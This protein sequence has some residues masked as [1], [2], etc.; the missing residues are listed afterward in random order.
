MADEP[1]D[2]T[3]SGDEYAVRVRAYAAAHFD[4]DEH[5][6]VRWPDATAFFVSEYTGGEDGRAYPVTI[7]GEI[8]GA[9]ESFAEAEQRLGASVR[10][11]FSILAVASNA[12]MRDPL[13]VASYGLDLS[14]PQPFTGY[15]TPRADEWFPPGARRFDVEATLALMTAVGH[16]PQTDLLHRAIESYRRAVG[17]WVPEEHLLAGEFLFIAAETLSRFLIESRAHAAGITPK[18][19]AR[20][21]GLDPERLRARYLLD[22]VFGRDQAALDA[23]RSASDGFEHGYM[24]VEDVRGL[25]E[26]A[27]EHSMSL[28]RRALIV[29]SGVDAEMSER[30]LASEYDDPRGLVPVVQ[31]MQGK[32]RASDPGDAPALEMAAVDLDWTGSRP[33]AST[34]DEGGVDVTFSTNVRVAAIQS[35]AQLELSSFGMRAAHVRPTG[36]LETE[37]SRAGEADTD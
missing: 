26:P 32:I 34:N 35:G 10:N 33:V 3:P 4:F 30:L 24:S 8:R 11:V 36:E 19:L 15:E 13:A 27:L 21:Q 28:V 29:A 20:S 9:G 1:P 25:V 17:H 31:F 14:R 23:M 7:H 12:A 5:L 16:H 37:V 6:V 22:D 2:S 18:N